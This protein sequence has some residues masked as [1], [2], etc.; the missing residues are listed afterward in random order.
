[1]NSILDLFR[2][3][4][5][6]RYLYIGNAGFDA[7]KHLKTGYQICIRDNSLQ[8]NNDYDHFEHFVR[9]S[10]NEEDGPLSIW[11]LIANNTTSD[12]EAFQLFFSLLKRY[13]AG[14]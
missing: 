4:E 13:D 14:Q 8:T 1:M 6:N 5:R 7:L 9:S 11:T 3:M 12:D 2:K 10:L